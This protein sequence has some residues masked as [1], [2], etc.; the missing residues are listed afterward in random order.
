MYVSWYTLAAKAT[1]RQ[2]VVLCCLQKVYISKTNVIELTDLDHGE[3]YCFSIQAYIPS[4]TIN[5][6]L[7][8]ESHFQ[9]SDEN[10]SVFKG[11]GLFCFG[12]FCTNVTIKNILGKFSDV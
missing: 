1:S 4:R 11:K 12:H 10:W 9:C 3:S 5:K 8:K 6:Q 2:V 7:G